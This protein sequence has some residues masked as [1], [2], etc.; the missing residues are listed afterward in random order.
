MTPNATPGNMYALFPCPGLKIFPLCFT[1]PNGEPDEKMHFPCNANIF[2]RNSLLL[3]MH[4]ANGN[5]VTYI[6]MVVSLL[7]G[8]LGLAGR[9]AQGENQRSF[10]IFR[11]FF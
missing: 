3:K 6:R 11:H 9:V 7:R 8:A 10:I 5:S 2:F 1:S 4:N